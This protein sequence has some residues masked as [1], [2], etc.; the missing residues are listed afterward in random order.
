MRGAKCVWCWRRL[1]VKGMRGIK[2][3]HGMGI[4]IALSRLCVLTIAEEIDYDKVDNG[5]G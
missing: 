3:P 5:K 2:Y 4:F 1:S